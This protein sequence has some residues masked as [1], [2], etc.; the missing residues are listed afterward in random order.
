MG[1]EFIPAEGFSGSPK[2]TGVGPQVDSK[3]RDEAELNDP[4]VEIILTNPAESSQVAYH[5]CYCEV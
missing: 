4:E 3:K 5:S 1:A 2:T